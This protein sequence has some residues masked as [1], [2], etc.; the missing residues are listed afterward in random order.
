MSKSKMVKKLNPK[1]ITLDTRHTDLPATV[2]LVNEV[3]DELKMEIKGEVGSLRGEMNIFK[4]EMYAFREETRANFSKV[5]SKLDLLM[6]AIHRTQALMEEQRSENRIVLD[7]Y[8]LLWQ[9]QEQIDKSLTRLK[10]F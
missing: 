8:K 1:E 9:K 7:S 5:D 3:R 10:G 4:A 6:A 2:G